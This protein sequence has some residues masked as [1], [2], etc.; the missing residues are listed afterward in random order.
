MLVKMVPGQNTELP[1]W[2]IMFKTWVMA[3]VHFY[4]GCFSYAVPN[5]IP[6]PV[7]MTMLHSFAVIV[8]NA[9]TSC[10]KLSSQTTKQNTDVVFVI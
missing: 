7:F 4:N 5:A 3:T 2:M 9:S 1:L 6:L 10:H 8:V